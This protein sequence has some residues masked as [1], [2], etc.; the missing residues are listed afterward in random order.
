MNQ[1]GDLLFLRDFATPY[2][3]SVYKSLVSQGKSGIL[4]VSRIK[5]YFNLPEIIFSR[6]IKIMNENGDER[7]DHDEWLSFFL[8]LT[9]SSH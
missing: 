7:I 4:E 2:F 8:R 5:R 1:G 9:C 3:S 6:V